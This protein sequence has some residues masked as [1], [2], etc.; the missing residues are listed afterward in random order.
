MGTTCCSQRDKEPRSRADTPDSL[1]YNKLSQASEVQKS[2][3]FI[4]SY[5]EESKPN[6]VDDLIKKR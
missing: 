2:L 4:T 3:A 6:L 5:F 1:I